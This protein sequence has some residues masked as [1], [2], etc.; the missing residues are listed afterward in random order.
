MCVYNTMSKNFIALFNK[1]KSFRD[2]VDPNNDAVFNNKGE[3]STGALE[4]GRF[5]LNRAA[6]LSTLANVYPRSLT[7]IINEHQEPGTSGGGG[8][9]N[10]DTGDGK[11][12]DSEDIVNVGKGGGGIPDTSNL[13]GSTELKGLDEIIG[14]CTGGT[15]PPNNNK[16]TD[17]D[18]SDLEVGDILIVGNPPNSQTVTITSIIPPGTV[19]IEP[20]LDTPPLDTE[21]PYT[22]YKQT[23]GGGCTFN[24]S[25][26]TD[27]I[28]GLNIEELEVGDTLIV[29]EPPN[30]IEVKIIGLLPPDGVRVS[31]SLTTPPLGGGAGGTVKPL[32]VEKKNSTE[33][34]NTGVIDLNEDAY[35][36]C[37]LDTS[38]LAVGDTIVV[39]GELDAELQTRVITQILGDSCVKVG[40]AFTSGTGSGGTV[41]RKV[42][43]SG[44][45]WFYSELW[46]WFWVDNAYPNWLFS[47][48]YNCWVFVYHL[49]S[50]NGKPFGPVWMS[51]PIPGIWCVVG[52]GRIIDPT[53]GEEI[54]CPNPG[55]PELTLPNNDGVGEDKSEELS[56]NLKKAMG[57]GGF[58]EIDGFISI[59]KR[60]LNKNK[61]KPD[62]S[63]VPGGGGG[64]DLLRLYHP[65]LGPF[66]WDGV[67]NT[68]YFF[69]WSL[70]LSFPEPFDPYNFNT[71]VVCKVWKPDGTEGD[72]SLNVTLTLNP[73]QLKRPDGSIIEPTSEE[74]G[75]PDDET[76]KDVPPDEVVVTGPS[77]L[78]FG[79]HI[80][81]HFG[82][83]YM[84]YPW[85][86]STKW[87]GWW[88]VGELSNEGHGTVGW[89]Y[90]GE[91][92]KWYWLLSPN[93]Y[94]V[95][96]KGG[97]GGPEPDPDTTV[98]DPDD[99][100]PSEGHITILNAFIEEVEA[101]SGVAVVSF[102]GMHK[103]AG[104]RG[105]IL[106]RWN[107][108]ANSGAGDWITWEQFGAYDENVLISDRQL[109][110][111]SGAVGQ[112]IRLNWGGTS[113]YS[114]EF[115]I[116]INGLSG[117]NPVD[118]D[119][120]PQSGG[121]SEDPD[122]KGNVDVEVVYPHVFTDPVFGVCI[123]MQEQDPLTY[124]WFYTLRY[125]WVW[126]DVTQKWFYIVNFSDWF[127][128][129]ALYTNQTGDGW[130]WSLSK[131]SWWWNA[132]GTF[133]NQG[134]ED[135]FASG[136]GKHEC[137]N[138]VGGSLG[139]NETG[140]TE[141][142]DLEEADNLIATN[143]EEITLVDGSGIIIGDAETAPGETDDT[144]NNSATLLVTDRVTNVL[145]YKT[146][147]DA[148]G[149]IQV[150]DQV[151]ILGG[152]TICAD[153]MLENS[154]AS[155]ELSRVLSASDVTQAYDLHFG[156]SN[157]GFTGK[158]SDEDGGYWIGRTWGDLI[159][160]MP[161]DGRYSEPPPVWQLDRVLS[162][163]D[164][165]LAYDLYMS[166]HGFTGGSSSNDGGYWVGKTWG[167]LKAGILNAASNEDFR[168]EN[169]CNRIQ[170][171]PENTSI[172]IF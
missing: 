78:P 57:S 17:I 12:D 127:W 32:K 51:K 50:V 33:N 2:F 132:F 115:E 1:I 94:K 38:T 170:I 141:E 82:F 79:W 45:G 99:F 123:V 53:T 105:L 146:I 151:E 88:Y 155:W 108:L 19:I 72:G 63:T 30:T 164:V 138:P 14:G 156:I 37:G 35:K 130:V 10:N 23:G 114:N 149:E 135:Y 131:S 158:T 48:K 122:P 25:G 160:Q 119:P 26:N 163:D 104:S 161:N 153:T 134:G 117:I 126:G 128:F 103:S 139:P 68:V 31:P 81:D 137:T 140:G 60:G 22:V 87:N 107:P 120:P 80:S 71:P 89:V 8:G 5:S 29:G 76:E 84:V 56:V 70:W 147:T 21:G 65:T 24:N 43:T 75:G 166:P 121:G 36:I 9:G 172:L 125:G 96:S 62:G 85:I 47:N 34:T 129:G 40:E 171:E 144:I 154:T 44:K 66:L 73:I 13:D 64:E 52:G 49:Q 4:G 18:I 101:E 167:D 15:N 77:T 27:I 142:N 110:G 95:T 92:S 7:T 152:E 55:G 112:R 16:L 74:T 102:S 118:S 143:G 109:T 106:D 150:P 54:G 86:Y 93:I 159:A 59:C 136:P 133:T 20:G 116:E 162:S 67:S 3:V 91:T 41:V 165:M 83:Y 61:L 6:V 98:L 124:G 39:G 169:N 90:F 46:G 11:G 42:T 100:Q 113:I 111:G 145:T 157:H 97:D 148:D 69:Y 58:K 168:Y 28:T